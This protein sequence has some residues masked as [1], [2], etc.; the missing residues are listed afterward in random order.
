MRRSRFREGPNVFEATGLFLE[1]HFMPITRDDGSRKY[2]WGQ[3]LAYAVACTR[4]LLTGQGRARRPE[5]R[6][7]EAARKIYRDFPAILDALGL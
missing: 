5:R 4:A 6:F 1:T 3:G 2:V 7:L